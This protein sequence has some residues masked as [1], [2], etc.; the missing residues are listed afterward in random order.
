M[1]RFSNLIKG[2]Y[3]KSF[4]SLISGTAFAQILM[5]LAS[6]ILTRVYSPSDFGDYAIFSVMCSIISI[7]ACLRYD[8]TIVL[9]KEDKEAINLFVLSLIISFCMGTFLFVFLILLDIFNISLINKFIKKDWYIMIPIVTILLGLFQAS[10]YLFTRKKYFNDL[11]MSKVVQST[12]NVLAQMGSGYLLNLGSKGLIFGQIFGQICVSIYFLLKIFRGVLISKDSIKF[13]VI[14]KLFSRYKS[15]PIYNT[16]PSLL[17]ML[18]ISMPLFFMNYFYGNTIAGYYSLANRI[19]N[20]PLALFGSA[21]SQILFQKLAELYSNNQEREFKVLVKTFL[22][23]LM[24]MGLFT[25]TMFQFSPYIFSFVFGDKWV[26][27]G[28]YAQ[29]LSVAAVS[30]LVV[31]PLSNVLIVKEK[32]KLLA[33]WQLLYLITTLL[34]LSYSVTFKNPV[35]TLNFYVVNEILLYFIYLLFI[36]KAADFNAFRYFRISYKR[37]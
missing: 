13:E 5:F 30:R 14:R 10:N 26:E 16:I 28:E 7:I 6:P 36:L 25:V 31:S 20:I 9:P 19:V 15:F 33:I 4:F 1:L 23:R 32:Q 12:S 3:S 37:G 24:L 34:L 2:K 11:A 35:V 17:D 22:K 18:S 21:I 29:Y 8:L 27:A